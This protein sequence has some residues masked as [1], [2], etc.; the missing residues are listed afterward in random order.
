VEVL[1]WSSGK[2][3]GTEAELG[4]R[5]PMVGWR[6]AQEGGKG[7]TRAGDWP[8]VFIGGAQGVLLRRQEGKEEGPAGAGR[9]A[10]RPGHGASTRA[11]NTRHRARVSMWLGAHE[12]SGGAARAQAG[13]G[14]PAA[15][16]RRTG[17]RR[18]DALE[19]G[20]AQF[21]F[22]LTAFDRG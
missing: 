17:A 10:M 21:V 6:R 18:R 15:T 22:R 4:S 14:D 8:V 13:V 12:A 19:R 7:R 20:A 5:A 2:V 16:R 1:E 9:H 11:V 3:C